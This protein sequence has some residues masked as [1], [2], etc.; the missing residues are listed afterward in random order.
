MTDRKQRERR[1]RVLTL[2]EQT[3]S[4][5]AT[6]R[7]AKISRKTVRRVLQ[8][9][10]TRAPPRTT[11]PRPSK[12]DAF[13]PVVRRLVLEDKLTATLVLEELRQLGYLGGYSILKTYVRRIR[14]TAKV[15]VTTRLEH[16]PGAEGQVDW[17]PYTVTLCGET[18]LVHAFSLVLPYSAYMVLRF[19]LDE[20]LETLLPLHD[21][22][23]ADVGAIPRM[24]T[25]DNMTTV[26]RHVGPN[27]V[28]INPR[29]DAYRKEQGD[30]EI[31]LIDP[32]HPNQHASVERHF[33]YVEKN[34]LLRRRS[35]FAD[36]AD[37]NAH[38][39]WW[40]DKVA[41][42]RIHGSTRERP[43]DR[44]ARERPLMIPLPSLLP[45]PFRAL[46]RAV[47]SDYCVAVETIRYSVHPR[48][49]GQAATVRLY[50]E[51][52]EIVIGS[53]VVAVHARG[54]VPRQRH[55]LTEHEEAF[56]QCTPSRRLLEHAF[57]RLGPTA[58][59]YYVGLKAQRAG[60]AGYHLQRILKLADRHG[61]A[62]VLGAMA[63]AARYGNYSADAVARVIAGRELRRQNTAPKG[64]V[65][66]P[67]ERVRRWLEGLDVET[68]D[69]A[70]YDRLI[71]R[72][73]PDEGDGNAEN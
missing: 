63:H 49:V 71:D 11:P 54:T 25:Y 69:L 2:F 31:R 60:G 6:A 14:P 52:V 51:R 56:K 28:W 45:E 5:R 4:I 17:S 12:L 22:A 62:V 13:R 34:C 26:G 30:F 67:P 47:Q 35:R 10:D 15:K 19:T 46:Q 42:V 44:L 64:Q 43:L 18:R 36:L 48:H 58:E 50:G 21:E 40:C 59:D 9:K 27:E 38:A 57:L 72:L 33:D 23:F 55:V 32:Y 29:F 3:G 20:T 73:G 70:H 7:R 39:K 37:L 53:E 68:G 8:G 65:P 66:T 41:N 1:S 61:N 16:A 24:M